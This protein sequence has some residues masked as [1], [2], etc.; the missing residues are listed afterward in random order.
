MDAE[1]VCGF[2]EAAGG[3]FEGAED[4]LALGLA[5]RVVVT[6]GGRRGVSAGRVRAGRGVEDGLGQV[7]GQDALGRAEDDGA[8]DGVLQLADVARPVVRD[9]ARARLRREPRHAALE[10]RGVFRDEVAG[11]Q[12]DVFAP[13]AQGGQLEGDDVEAVVQ[14][15]TK[16]PGLDGLLQVPVRRR[17]DAHVNADGARAADALE[18]ALLQDAQ[19][20]RLHGRRHLADLVEEERAAVGHFEL[21]LLLRERAGEGA[22]L[23][24]EQLRLQQRLRQRRAVDGDEGSLAARAVLVQGARGQLLARARLA[25]HEHRGVGRRDAR[26]ELVDALDG[27]ALADH[28][29]LDRRLGAQQVALALQPLDVARVVERDGG[30]PADGRQ[31]LQV[32]LV[33]VRR[34]VGRRQ[35]DGAERAAVEHERRA[36]KRAEPRGPQALHRVESAL[37]EVARE[38]GR[39]LLQDLPQDR[40]AHLYRARAALGAFEAELGDDAAV[41]ADEQ[42]GAALGGHGLEDQAEQLAL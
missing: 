35:V 41:L 29:V 13:L 27:R 2:G 23:V 31:Q 16:G 5:E 19:Q 6:G 3:L 25:A 1:E 18:L 21:A 40:A 42:D 15:L 7:F 11:E 17:D 20:L 36:Q 9:E 37:D 14:V 4:E 12:R 24:A 38:D 33:E 22:A 34:E 26:D 10:L 32:P 30:Y 39:P 8:L 28:P